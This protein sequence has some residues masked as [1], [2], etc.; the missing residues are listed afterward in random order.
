[1]STR[2]A[3]LILLVIAFSCTEVDENLPSEEEL[4]RW[5][6]FVE[7]DEGPVWSLFEDS[8]G[9][10]WVGTNEGVSV[11]NGSTFQS[12]S[13]SN[14]LFN[15]TVVAIIEDPEGDMWFG[16][17]GGVSILTSDGF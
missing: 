7:F 2:Y 6:Y 8:D 15:T 9:E 17:P 11:F 10:V 5:E 12:Y 16:T 13:V 14:G 4:D 1:M 3:T